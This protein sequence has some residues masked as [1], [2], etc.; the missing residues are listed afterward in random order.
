MVFTHRL[1][2]STERKVTAA[3]LPPEAKGIAM[4]RLR[5]LTTLLGCLILTHS[6]YAI[7]ASHPHPK[8]LQKKAAATPSRAKAC[9]AVW[10][11][12]LQGL[13]S[14]A[15]DAGLSPAEVQAAHRAFTVKCMAEGPNSPSIAQ[16][17]QGS[18]S[19]S[20]LDD[21]LDILP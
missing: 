10:P 19:G 18:S 16:V 14:A 4:S 13:N 3:C 20:A 17:M 1:Y 2:A 9:A 21:L 5:I 7:A 11:Q 6:G 8:H 15:A 12:Y